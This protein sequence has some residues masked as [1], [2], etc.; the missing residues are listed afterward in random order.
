M[1][2]GVFCLRFPNGGM[3][4]DNIYE[5][6]CVLMVEHEKETDILNAI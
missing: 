4:N 6:V 3:I 5:F 2:V 1:Y